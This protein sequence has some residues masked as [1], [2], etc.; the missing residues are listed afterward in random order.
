MPVPKRKRSR[1]RRDKRFANKGMKVKS[2]TQCANCQEPLT[3]HAA[4][5]ACGYYKGKKVLTTK[6]ER[7]VKRIE[8]RQAKQDTKSQAKMSESPESEDTK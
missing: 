2:F 6:S 3:T 1:S 7:T 5:R 8:T 4:C